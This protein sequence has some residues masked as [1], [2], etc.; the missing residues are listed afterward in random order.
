MRCGL[1][2]RSLTP[3]HLDVG[4]GPGGPTMRC[5]RR[6][7]VD[8]RVRSFRV[9][10]RLAAERQVV[11]R[12]RPGSAGMQ[13]WNPSR[14]DGRSAKPASG[15]AGFSPVLDQDARRTPSVP[16]GEVHAW[17]AGIP[18]A[19]GTVLVA[20]LGRKPAGYRQVWLIFLLWRE[21]GK[22]KKAVSRLMMEKPTQTCTFLIEMTDQ[23][24][25]FITASSSIALF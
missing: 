12:S 18:G 4:Q 17:V 19:Q 10:R 20:L 8:R 3:K 14:S 16:D 2:L 6:A 22:E 21:E 9:Q 15:A 5:S 24:S 25:D 23:P 11:T 13:R 1:S 7:A